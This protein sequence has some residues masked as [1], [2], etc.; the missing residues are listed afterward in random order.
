MTVT[1]R[2]TVEISDKVKAGLDRLADNTDQ[3]PSHLAS[4]AIAAYV[5]HELAVIDGIKRGIADMSGNRVVPHDEAMAEIFSIIDKA[6]S[7]RQ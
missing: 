2:I 1:T 5:D 6:Q 7:Q 4:E 3:S